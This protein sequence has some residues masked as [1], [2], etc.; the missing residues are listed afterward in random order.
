[1]LDSL[2]TLQRTHYCGDLRAAD[3][4]K[5]VVLMGWVHKRRD[6]GNL[7]FIDLRDR[8]GLAQIV[9]NKEL[10]A[11]AHGRAEE[12]RSEY[13]VAVVG[14]V[15]K[16]QK[17][18]PDLTSGEVEIVASEL[19][20]LNTS[21]TPPFVVEDDL[22]ANEETR[23]RYRYLDLR[24]TKPRENL[25]LRHRVFLEI[26]KAM[27]EMGFY[28]I[29][30]PTLTRSTPEGARDYL[31]PSRV[32]RGQFYALPQS[33]QL[34]KQILMIG[35][36]DRY[37]QIAKCFRDEELRANRQPEFTQLDVEMSFP[38][39]DTVFGVIENVMVRACAIAG[40]TVKGPFRRM[41][42]KDAIR[43]YGSDKPDLRFGMELNDVTEHF[44]AARETLRL[45]GNVQAMVAPGA[46][47]FSRKQ[48]D[49]LTE[50]AKSLGARGVY[51]IKVTP[52]GATSPLEKNL[53][54]E[55]LKKI[56][57]E[58][59]AKPGD[60]IVVVTAKE[61]IPGTDAAAMIAGQLR[62]LLA[63]QL[64]LIPK[65]SWEFVWITGF[66][67][68]EW[69]TTEKAV[70]SAQHPFTG[71]VDEDISK[72]E[73]PSD[74]VRLSMRSKGYDVVLNGVELGSGSIRI[75]QQALQDRVFK[76]LG[77]SEE[78]RRSRFGFFLDALTYGT[79]PHGGIGIG[80]DRFIQLLA[81]EE[82]IREVIAFPKT[83][84]AQ[85]LMAEAPSDVDRD[86]LDL[87]GI[88]LKSTEEK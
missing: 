79:P 72:L 29:E 81:G 66:A 53:G 64:K 65:D 16:R 31:V 76:M 24:R 27:D 13:V 40:I 62:L 49:E 88:Q 21:K 45:E 87:L 84:K 48:L 9:F 28:E 70:V 38:T 42:Y 30:T 52:E 78:Q 5:D 32:H 14:R 46:A 47:T 34:F 82:S 68:F 3:T 74:E 51:T 83:S 80:L 67:L 60:L 59:S 15:V 57:A 17:V 11:A 10:N 77:L 71:I 63:D 2:G 8:S 56:A 54:A 7:L 37:F 61:Q 73:D 58:V 55:T 39:E 4:D 1:M 18:N 44:A 85:D 23:L 6:L 50:K 33:P 86:Q 69:N 25:A 12:L 36:M 43:R 41:E 75:H 35:G 22:T 19:R 26:R 20:I